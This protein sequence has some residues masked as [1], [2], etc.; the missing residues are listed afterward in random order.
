MNSDQNTALKNT[1]NWE[2]KLLRHELNELQR[3]KHHLVNKSKERKLTAWE[4]ERTEY[5][6]DEVMELLKQFAKIGKPT[7]T[8]IKDS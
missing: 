2:I 6:L 1:I 5:I 3:E 7:I 8:L 4:I